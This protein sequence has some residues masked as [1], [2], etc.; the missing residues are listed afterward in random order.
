MV[1]QGGNTM[2]WLLSEFGGLAP[3][4]FSLNRVDLICMV[5]LGM[6]CDN[7]MLRRFVWP[8]HR[9]FS[10]AERRFTPFRDE[11]SPL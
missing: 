6:V 1:L 3:R 5:G 10:V 2:G 7:I 11:T 9:T 4:G 8:G